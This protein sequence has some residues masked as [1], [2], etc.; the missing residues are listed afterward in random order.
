[1]GSGKVR[2]NSNR[3]REEYKEELL[4]ARCAWRSPAW[5]GQDEDGK[6][7]RQEGLREAVGIGPLAPGPQR[8]GTGVA[9]DTCKIHARRLHY[10]WEKSH[11]S[12][13]PGATFP[14]AQPP[15]PIGARND[16][17]NRVRR[18]HALPS[19][20]SHSLVKTARKGNGWDLRGWVGL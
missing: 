19:P 8:K 12:C 9:G 15:G 10:A 17:S 1:M 4:L 6:K 7:R 5:G 2:E 18:S 20:K 11:L 14:C 16:L 13:L 3:V